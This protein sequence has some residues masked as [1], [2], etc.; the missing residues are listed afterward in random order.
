MMIETRAGVP[1]GVLDERLQRL[2][3][4]IEGNSG[5]IK[6]SYTK[7]DRLEAKVDIGCDNLQAMIRELLQK[8]PVVEQLAVQP[9]QEEQ[10][11]NRVQANL[12]EQI[13]RAPRETHGVPLGAE[14]RNAIPMRLLN[15]DFRAQ[16][17]QPRVGMQMGEFFENGQTGP[18]LGEFGDP[19]EERSVRN[20]ARFMPPFQGHFDAPYEKPWLGRRQGQQA[21]FEPHAAPLRHGTHF[22]DPR[23]DQ[24]GL[25]DQDEACFDPGGGRQAQERP[26]QWQGA[27]HGD[28]YWQ[29]QDGPAWHQGGASSNWVQAN[30]GEQLPITPPS[31]YRLPIG[32]KESNV[33][34]MRAPNHEV[35]TMVQPEPQREAQSGHGGGA[36]IVGKQPSIFEPIEPIPMRA[37]SRNVRTMRAPNHEVHFNPNQPWFGMPY[38]D[39]F[40]PRRKRLNGGIFLNPIVGSLCGLGNARPPPS[41]EGQCGLYGEEYWREKR[42]PRQQQQF[43]TCG[44]QAQPQRHVSQVREPRNAPWPQ[45]DVVE[46]W[47]DHGGGRGNCGRARNYQGPQDRDPYGKNQDPL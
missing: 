5:A 28:P 2:Q 25:N 21:Q 9:R 4:Q 41:F 29:E 13:P 19:I 27:H 17:N 15:Q 33:L 31:I 1:I 35:Q 34:S 42:F 24:W 6:Q 44:Q 7:F 14:M 11:P 37:E 43:H 39:P 47:Y 16:A 36:P 22:G 32:S 12:G 30:F 26:R 45:G 10:T 38:D 46:P 8:Q 23:E 20:N 18:I 3:T 40:E